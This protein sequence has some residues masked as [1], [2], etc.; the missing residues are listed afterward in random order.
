MIRIIGIGSPFGD[1]AV[2][3]RVIEHLQGRVPD[4]V[5]LLSL[6]RPGAGLVQWLEGADHV[7]LIDGIRS[8]GRPGEVRSVALD[9]LDAL[10]ESP[11]THG[12]GLAHAL[13]LAGAMGALPARLAIHAIELGTLERDKLSPAVAA[14]A[15]TLADRLAL[16]FTRGQ[17]LQ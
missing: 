17:Q 12:F 10:P 3:W 7:V 14:G 2:G 11:S 8:D 1:D 13:R 5:E 15:A 6:D 9:A 16:E 4:A